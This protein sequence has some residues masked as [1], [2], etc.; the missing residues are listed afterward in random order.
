MTILARFRSLCCDV[1]IQL[2]KS[3]VSNTTASWFMGTLKNT[4]HSYICMK[5]E[6]AWH[7]DSP[8]GSWTKFMRETTKRDDIQSMVE[9]LDI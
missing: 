4:R 9:I 1:P 7:S 8:A 3:V 5:C 2:E 6:G